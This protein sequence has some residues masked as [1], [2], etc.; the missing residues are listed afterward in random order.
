MLPYAAKVVF[1]SKGSTSRHGAWRK[2]FCFL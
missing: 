1:L 2:D